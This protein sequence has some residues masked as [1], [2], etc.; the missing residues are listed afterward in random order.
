MTGSGDKIGIKEYTV[1][2][3]FL[4]GIKVTDDIP[5][6]LFES[7]QTASW[8]G[9]I[10]SGIFTVLPLFLLLN[11]T[12]KYEEE[13]FIDITFRLL[14]KYIGFLML[15]F[16]W[17]FGF[18]YIVLDTATYTDIISTMYYVKTPT[19]VIYA[20]LI[21]VSAY[22]A[23]K[24][25]EQIGSVTWAIFPYLQFSLLLA[26]VLTIIHGNSHFL[27]PIFGSGEWE[28]I[29]ESFMDVSIYMD[30]IYLAILIPYIKSTNDFRKG[31]WIA[32]SVVI[33]NISIST[34]SF[35]MLFDYNTAMSLNYPYHETIRSIRLGFLGNL[36]T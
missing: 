30:F 18:F 14:G 7:L 31:T 26:I 28:V 2:A 19:I 22:G 3:I 33:F 12:K 1:I 13:S 11:L 17:A 21:G 5:A 24:G 25:L 10:I 20:L 15:F 6:M 36:E 29:K 27:F 8:M 16:L 35:I 4:I 23:K 32:F 34:A 9:P